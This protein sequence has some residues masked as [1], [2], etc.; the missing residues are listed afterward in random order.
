MFKLVE[1]PLKAGSNSVL[2]NSSKGDSPADGRYFSLDVRNILSL[3]PRKE[4]NNISSAGILPFSKA[5][6]IA[7][8]LGKVVPFFFFLHFLKLS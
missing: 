1:N 6:T 4:T 2:M 3:R 5:I 8:T 7:G